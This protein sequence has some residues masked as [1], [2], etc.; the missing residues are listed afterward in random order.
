M[1][2]ETSWLDVLTRLVEG[3]R[4]AFLEVNRLI[5]G[6][7]VRRQVY[8]LAEEWDDLR[9]EVVLAIVAATRA[10]RLREADAVVAF[11]G[12]IVRNKVADRLGTRYRT[13]EKDGTPWEEVANELVD[14]R[15]LEAEEKQRG[16]ELW[17]A[18]GELPSEE[19]AVLRGVYAEGKTYEV[20]AAETGLPL[21]TMKRRLRDGLAAV[22]ARFEESRARRGP[23]RRPRRTSSR[24]GTAAIGEDT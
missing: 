12:G 7:L 13:H 14:R 3:D 4:L 21:G 17:R 15:A 11:V 23:I 24:G 5:T 2:G 20:V 6:F 16:A 22:R 1:A 10:G 8:D 19:R 9:Q 18:V